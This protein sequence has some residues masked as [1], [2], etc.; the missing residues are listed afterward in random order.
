MEYSIK[1]VAKNVEISEQGLYKRIKTNYAEY[2][3]KGYIVVKSVEQPNGT[4]KEQIFIT[5]SGIDDLLKTKQLRQGAS[6]QGFEELNQVAKPLNQVEQPNDTA[7]KPS[8]EETTGKTAS[9]E[10]LNLLNQ[11]ITDLK[12]ENKRLNEKLDKQE[13]RFD[14]KLDKQK[15][16]FK[17]Q[18]EKQQEAYQKTLDRI[19]QSFNNALLQLPKPTEETP[20][21]TNENRQQ[22]QI[23]IETITNTD[24]E[25]KGLKKLFRHL[26]NKGE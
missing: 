7:T 16:E 24:T 19:M 8:N 21:Q 17:E 15:Q 20:T 23:Q 10:L 5:I 9:N 2:I 6:L 22:D 13:A 18:F 25:A 3:D 26:F 1:D 4:T 14:E 12:E 11:T